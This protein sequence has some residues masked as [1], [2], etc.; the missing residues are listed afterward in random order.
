MTLVNS[1]CSGVKSHAY[2]KPQ[3]PSFPSSQACDSSDHR[4]RDSLNC[5]TQSPRNLFLFPI[6]AFSHIFSSLLLPSS[7]LHSTY[8]I[9]IIKGKMLSSVRVI[10]RQSIVRNAGVQSSVALRQA[11]TVAS[12]WANVPQGP[13]VSSSANHPFLMSLC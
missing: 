2:F 6:D 1:G 9:E 5:I 10:A 8:L 12:T 7:L 13:P 11:S 3:L 4:C